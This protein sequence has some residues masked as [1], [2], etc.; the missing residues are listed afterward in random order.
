MRL[1]VGEYTLTMVSD[2]FFSNDAGAMFGRVPKTIWSRLVTVDD[3]NRMKLA[4]NCLLIQRNHKNILVNAGIGTK[5]NQK[6]RDIYKIAHQDT[7]VSSLE[8]LN[9]R[10]ENIDL[11]IFTHLH[12]DHCGA[13]TELQDGDPF[14]VFPNAQY[15]VQKDEWESAIH[16]NELTRGSYLTDNFLPLRERTVFIEGHTRLT[17]FGMPG[18]QLIKTAGHSEGHQIVEI[19]GDGKRAIYLSD[20]IPTTKHIHIPYLMAYDIDPLQVVHTKKIW[21]KKCI[22][23]DYTVIWEHDTEYSFSKIGFHNGKYVATELVRSQ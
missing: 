4:L 21:L 5:F 13:A 20:L 14:P 23:Q 19:T 11:V 12:F 10:P 18:I 17:A 1:Q 9:L 8:K 15:I 3:T 22:D 16:P 7:V 2:G 6:Y